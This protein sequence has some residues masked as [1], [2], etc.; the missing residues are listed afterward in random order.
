MRYRI[1]IFLEMAT[2]KKLNNDFYAIQRHSKS[3]ILILSVGTVAELLPILQLAMLDGLERL[4]NGNLPDSQYTIS[5]KYIVFVSLSP[6]SGSVRLDIWEWFT[7]P[8]GE[9]KPTK[10]GVNLS[11]E[12]VN[13]FTSLI[14]EHLRT[15]LDRCYLC[16]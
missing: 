1:S 13:I 12:E 16:L 8:D 11:V 4:S 10:W 3:Q 5:Q 14:E 7:N 9:S 6:D 2:F 15:A